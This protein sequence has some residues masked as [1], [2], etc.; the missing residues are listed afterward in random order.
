MWISKEEEEE[1]SASHREKS[2]VKWH[3]TRRVGRCSK[4]EG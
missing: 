3:T 1:S 2:T 4:R